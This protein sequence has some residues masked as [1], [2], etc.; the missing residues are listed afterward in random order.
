[1][2]NGLDPILIFHFY[3]AAAQVTAS[4]IPL[5]NDLGLNRLS[6]P[7]V[8]IY[9]SERATGIYI[10]SEDKNIDIET[11]IETLR[12]GADPVTNQKGLG[13][14]VT[15][16]M[17]ANKDSLG[18]T[19]LSAMSDLI[20]GKLTS[21][22]YGITYL[23]GPITI[24]NGLLHSFNVNTD[25]DTDKL[26]I[27]LEI[28]RSSGSKTSAVEVPGITGSASLSDGGNLTSVGLPGGGSSSVGG[29][30]PVGNG[31]LP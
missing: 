1:M 30:I 4:K 3:K 6:L 20:F 26:K 8:P 17:E 22:E 27:T 28:S 23:H 18:I 9:L 21:K 12:D 15:V 7:P 5:A 25:S 13:S 2:L 31:G 11:N 29:S 10:D 24:F 14:V 19:L 16:R